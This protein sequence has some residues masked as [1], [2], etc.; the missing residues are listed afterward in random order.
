MNAPF[1]LPPKFYNETKK[2]QWTKY[3]LSEDIAGDEI[4]CDDLNTT[5]RFTR[6][7]SL[8]I[9]VIMMEPMEPFIFLSIFLL[10]YN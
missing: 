3:L 7:S 8:K 6:G 4:V 5:I 2:P 1:P 10:I 9:K